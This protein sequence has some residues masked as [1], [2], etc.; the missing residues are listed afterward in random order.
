MEWLWRRSGVDFVLK[1][2]YPTDFAALADI[3]HGIAGSP[4]TVRDY[5]A[6]LQSE[7]GVNY[8]LCQMMFGDMNFADASHSIRLFAREVMPAFA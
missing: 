6:R 4:A 3:G 7:T 5:L 8:V 2:I 1:D